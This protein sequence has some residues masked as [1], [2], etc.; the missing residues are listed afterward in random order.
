MKATDEPEPTRRRREAGDGS[1]EGPVIQEEW[2]AIQLTFHGAAGVVTGSCFLLEVAGKRILIDCG[3]FQGSKALNE[4]NYG[5]FPFAPESIDAVLLT[6]AHIDHSGLL[7]K[8]VRL[9]FRGPIYATPPTED[10]L[11]IMLADSAHIQESE[12]ARLNRRRARQGKPL[13]EPIYTGKDAERTQRLIRARDMR[14]PFE[15]AP[16]VTAAFWPAGHMLGA[17]SIT[18]EHSPPGGTPHRIAFSGDLGFTDQPLI[19]D[20]DAT[21]LPAVDTV[22]MESTYGDRPRHRNDNRYSQL[23]DIVRRTFARGGNVIIPAFAVGRVQELLYGLHQMIHS[24]ELDPANVIVDSPLA[25]RATDIFCRHVERFDEE[26]RRF[27]AAVGE[28]PL[29]LR[30]LRMTQSVDESRA[31][32]NIRSGAIIISSS[33]MCEAGRIKHHL[34]HNLWREECSVVIVSYQAAGT[35]GRRLLD[36]A[37]MVRI[38]GEP[39]KVA[40]EIHQIDGFSAH[41]DQD[42]LVSWVNKLPSPPKSI[43]LVHGEPSA[44]AAL[45]QRLIEE[46]GVPVFTPRL[47][48]SVELTASVT[49]AAVPPTAKPTDSKETADMHRD[50]AELW[51]HLAALKE[52]LDRLERAEAP[53]EKSRR[54]IEALKELQRAAE[55]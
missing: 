31:I 25:V 32:N 7:P 45:R 46:V 12:V 50:A 9:G 15:I 34:K 53:W 55:S 54:I 42:E 40:A 36:G 21:A 11:E 37:S 28:C 26:A 30:D 2:I 44:Q 17:A 38:H 39:I 47:D 3:L 19:V 49:T 13:L 52:S 24:G 22:V 1:A 14:E 18:L 35:L 5:P 43:Y 23:A 16:H 6:H 41:A 10:L 48:E 33:G 8:L 4:R 27:A 51:E 20:V 29:Y